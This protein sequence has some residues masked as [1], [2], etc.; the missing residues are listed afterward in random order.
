MALSGVV[1][2]AIAMASA[3]IIKEQVDEKGDLTQAGKVLSCGGPRILI[4]GPQSHTRDRILQR[5]RE[6]TGQRRTGLQA[7]RDEGRNR[8]SAKPTY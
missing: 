5:I 2:H 6:L 4:F 1:Q 7:D 8:A 3:R